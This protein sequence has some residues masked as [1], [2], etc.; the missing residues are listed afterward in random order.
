MNDFNN[1]SQTK[2]LA[3]LGIFTAILLVQN[4]VPVLG[5]IPI[6]PLN[7]TI[8]HITVIIAAFSMGVKDGTI[9]GL[10]WGII[11]FIK[12]LTMPT[13]PLDPLIW[14]NPII[15]IIPRLMVGLVAGLAFYFLSKRLSDK[16]SMAISAFLGSMTN[17][18]LVMFFIYLFFN[19]EI[20]ELMNL[21]A[22][23]LAYGLL[24]IIVT[25]GIPEAVLAAIVSPIIV[26]PLQKLK[27]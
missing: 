11:R 20:G 22:S 23:N 3:Q 26:K 27:R 10:I 17:T 7:P 9:V 12:A 16:V 1:T 5:N 21:D 2:R 24:I 18:I 19:P 8:I 15:S 14:V 4:F 6:P 25:N 13:T